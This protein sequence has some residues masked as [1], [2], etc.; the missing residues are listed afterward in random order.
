MARISETWRGDSGNTGD[1]EENLWRVRLRH[2]GA[3]FVPSYRSAVSNWWV[4]HRVTV[5]GCRV[6][7]VRHRS[8]E[9]GTDQVSSAPSWWA[10]HRSDKFDCRTDG[11]WLFARC[12]L[13]VSKLDL[14][15]FGLMVIPYQS[16]SPCDQ[17][18]DKTFEF[19]S[20]Y[21]KLQVGRWLEE[22]KTLENFYYDYRF[23]D[24]TIR[25]WRADYGK[26]THTI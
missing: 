25:R 24:M 3:S 18:R 19:E 21:L 17:S 23:L 5:I 15:R 1:V 6:D 14:I 10:R 11:V 20:K 22:I 8:D 9:F 16:P 12:Q 2:K 4:M 13:G 26:Y 7:G